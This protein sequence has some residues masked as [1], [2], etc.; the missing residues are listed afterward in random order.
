MGWTWT[1][2]CNSLI[3]T[4]F[5]T[6]SGCGLRRQR[7]TGR[8]C[9]TLTDKIIKSTEQDQ[10][11]HSGRDLLSDITHT[12]SSTHFHICCRQK[13][14]WFFF[15]FCFFFLQC[16]C[17]WP[18]SQGGFNLTIG[19]IWSI[20]G[21][22]LLVLDDSRDDALISFPQGWTRLSRSTHFPA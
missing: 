3:W 1:G 7:A 15:L 4:H 11:Q 18:N 21:L 8:I 2:F 10:A 14:V 19:D 13:T 5:Y 9:I 6:G 20:A 22:I 16:I 17:S 12:G